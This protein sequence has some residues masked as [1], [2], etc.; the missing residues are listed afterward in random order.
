MKKKRQ[1]NTLRLYIS[2]M[3]LDNPIGIFLLMWPTMSSLWLANKNAPPLSL[4]LIFIL[5]VII[6]R[7]A[8]CVINDYIDSK[9]DKYV[10]RTKHRP[11]ASGLISILEV[12]IIFIILL[13]IAA[14]LVS[15]TNF[16]TIILSLLG[17][18][19]TCIY[20]F[21]KRYTNLV[22]CVLAITFSICIPMTWTASNQNLS[23]VCWLLFA[24][25]I[26][27]TIM[28]DTQYAMVDKTDD[29]KIGVKSMAIMFGS[30]DKY[31]IGFFQLVTFILMIII[32]VVLNFK[33]MFYV[34][35][36]II[37]LLFIY[38]QYLMLKC[39]KEHYFQAFLNNNYVGLIFFIDIVLNSEPFI[40][41]F[42]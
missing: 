40:G 9:I 14:F 42:Y 10:Q 16:I 21:I 28:Y 27:W 34:I 18:L 38:Q 5:G 41:Y 15:M 31:I 11:L 26:F 30:F 37:L 20:P 22:Q 7:T 35:L 19:L 25:N 36:C 23:I 13:L 2:I 8:G 1:I 12:K 33:S 3:R 4:F 17:L 39:T 29:L 24:E 32:G 6:M